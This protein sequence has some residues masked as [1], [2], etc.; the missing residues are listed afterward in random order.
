MSNDNRVFS[1]DA[2]IDRMY[3]TYSPECLKKMAKDLVGMDVTKEFGGPVIGKV[4]SAEVTEG[5]L[6]SR[7]YMPI[8]PGVQ[9]FVDYLNEL[10]EIDP[11][12]MERFIAPH[13]ECN[14]KLALHP[15]VQAWAHEE[16]EPTTYSARFIGVMNGFFGAFDE[17]R[18]A[19][20]GAICSV[21][22]DETGR[23]KGFKVLNAN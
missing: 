20:G 23:L 9:E 2:N 13:F 16:N 4:I 11:D 8:K 1:L 21:H 6:I 3:E 17:G 19:G 10:F 22:D 12:F 7:V 18:R 14:A 5:K 15:T